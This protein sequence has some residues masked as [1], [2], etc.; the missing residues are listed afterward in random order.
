ME[1]ISN[2]P[3]SLYRNDTASMQGGKK[4]SSKKTYD[5]IMTLKSDICTN[6]C[7]S[8]VYVEDVVLVMRCLNA[9]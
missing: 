6:T 2:R 8:S 9:H 5:I 1:L 3:N 4:A 7:F